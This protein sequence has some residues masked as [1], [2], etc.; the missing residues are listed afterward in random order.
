MKYDA[1]FCSCGRINLM[2]DS[3]Y[4]WL[5]DNTNRVIFRICK[6]CG[7]VYR[8]WL[9]PSSYGGYDLCGSSIPGGDCILDASQ[10]N[11]FKVILHD[12]I[13][14]PM[15]SG[16]Y[17]DYKS[18]ASI[19]GGSDFMDSV[20]MDNGENGCVLVDTDR[21]IREVN[22]REKLKSISGYLVGIDWS[23][24]EYDKG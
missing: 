16:R 17:A 10:R 4:D 3:E 20:G 7:S 2:E 14:V 12:G 18:R 22:D 5:Q 15:K 9:D 19:G 13:R 24:T 1:W 8:V 21:L 11:D 23:G 6:N